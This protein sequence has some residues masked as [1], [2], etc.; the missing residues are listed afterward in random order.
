MAPCT[1]EK[2]KKSENQAPSKR[3][4]GKKLPVEKL[5]QNPN[6]VNVRRCRDNKQKIRDENLQKLEALKKQNAEIK[7]EIERKQIAIN[8]AREAIAQQNRNMEPQQPQPEPAGMFL[9]V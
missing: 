3:R 6:A 9:R 4:G 1:R 2:A 8:F 7:A 5:A